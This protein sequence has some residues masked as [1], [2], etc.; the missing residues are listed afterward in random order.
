[1][2]ICWAMFTR[3]T[4]LALVRTALRRSRVVALLGPRQYGKTTPAREFV[5]ADF[6]ELLRSRGFHQSGASR[7]TRDCA[8][9]GMT[10][11]RWACYS[12]S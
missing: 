2:V 11:T 10:D 3:T 7:G 9:P 8:S 12:F 1:M 6:A 4:D 5:S